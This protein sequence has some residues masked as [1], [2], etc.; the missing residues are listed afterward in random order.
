M[1]EGEE[2]THYILKTCSRTEDLEI[3]VSMTNQKVIFVSA[4]M[5]YCAV[6]A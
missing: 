6:C 5:F 4:E 2:I 1:R 3:Y